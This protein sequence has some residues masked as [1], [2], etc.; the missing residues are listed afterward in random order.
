M[1]TNLIFAVVIYQGFLSQSTAYSSVCRC[2]RPII[3]ASN[4]TDEFLFHVITDSDI[5]H[6]TNLEP[7]IL[8]FFVGALGF[9]NNKSCIVELKDR[10]P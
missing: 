7:T 3:G 9:F 1:H 2:N 4:V 8:Y 10:S 5:R 6:G